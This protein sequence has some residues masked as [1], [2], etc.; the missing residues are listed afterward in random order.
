MQDE[1]R[2]RQQQLEEMRQRE[3][4]D[5][6]R[7]EEE[8]RRQE[9]E[10]T[11]REAEQKVLLK[12]SVTWYTSLQLVWPAGVSCNITRSLS[13]QQSLGQNCKRRLLWL[14]T[15]TVLNSVRCSK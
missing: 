12:S 13:L 15:C 11:K 5:R 7:Q 2:R 14:L 4:E 6:A 9:E 1:E 3:A 10:R 8:R